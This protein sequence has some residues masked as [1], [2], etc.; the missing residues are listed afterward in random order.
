MLL[1]CSIHVH[2]PTNLYF[3]RQHVDPRFFLQFCLTTRGDTH[4]LCVLSLSHTD[5][6]RSD[7]CPLSDPRRQRSS[8]AQPFSLSRGDLR[9][10]R[11]SLSW[12]LTHCWHCLDSS[13]TLRSLAVRRSLSDGLTLGAHLT[14]VAPSATCLFLL[15]AY[16]VSRSDRAPSIVLPPVACSLFCCTLLCGHCRRLAGS[17]S[18][19]CH[20][21]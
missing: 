6:C 18:H 21:M 3:A 11:P 20:Q 4:P 9:S 1:S 14:V 5:T 16:T 15:L 8:P 2:I 19:R 17:G 13:R 12:R 10:W 7:Y